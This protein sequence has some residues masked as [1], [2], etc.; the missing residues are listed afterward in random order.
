MKKSLKI[1]T[2]LFSI[3]LIAIFCICFYKFQINKEEIIVKRYFDTNSEIL[4]NT[5]KEDSIN[6]MTLS[7]ILSQNEDIKSCLLSRDRKFCKDILDNYINILNKIPLYKN[8]MLHTHT[9]ELKSLVRSWNYDKFGDDLSNFRHTLLEMKSS[10]KSLYGVEA[11][12]CGVFIRGISP[13]SYDDKFLGSLE[14]MLDFN[15]LNDISKG[16]G[17]DI[18]IL[19]DKK[20]FLECFNQKEALVKNYVILNKNNTNL[21]ILSTLKKFDFQKD[22]FKKIGSNYFYKIKLYD[23]KNNK[24]GFI[25]LHF[26][27]NKIESGIS[28]LN[29]II[30]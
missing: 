25:V 23:I 29:A 24:I 6:A 13:I 7:V 16:R 28:K 19:V 26:N 11:G 22:D 1:F 27:K 30:N 20:Y 18:F 8:I 2:F 14:V 17:Y 21:N 10:K 15:H 4:L 12:R 3:V 5:I 9:D